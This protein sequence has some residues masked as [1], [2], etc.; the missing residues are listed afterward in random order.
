MESQR[1]P[2]TYLLVA[3]VVITVGF[4]VSRRPSNPARRE[5][6]EATH[7]P[8]E[9]ERRTRVSRV[10][11]VAESSA[12]TPVATR[13][14]LHANGVRRNVATPVPVIDEESSRALDEHPYVSEDM[15][16]LDDYYPVGTTFESAGREFGV[17]VDLLKAIAY[18]ESGG[19]HRHGVRT[20]RGTYGVMGLRE[21]P[22]ANTLEEAA[23]LLGV[24]KTVVVR[25]PVQNVRGGAVVLR[26]Y[27][28]QVVGSSNPAR[29]WLTALTLYSGRP[30]E[31]AVAYAR[32]I[33]NVLREGLVHKTQS[34]EEFNIGA[35]RHVLLSASPTQ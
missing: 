10:T 24:D 19:D 1:K 30:A 15:V 12:P 21:T 22:A 27:H 23:R 32:E 17:P 33:E 35:G 3:V 8:G 29:P 14:S 28:N 2:A 13:P 7:A 20:S 26:E 5:T 16:T 6:S 11:R 9:T 31:E 25:D 4:L 34:G 18:V